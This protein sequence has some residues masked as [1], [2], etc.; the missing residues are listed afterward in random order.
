[1]SYFKKIQEAVDYIEEN[2]S[3]DLSLE[4]LAKKFSFSKYHFHRL[5]LSIVGKPLMGYVQER[6]LSQA[7]HQ[8]IFSNQTVT[9]IALEL[10]YGSP[11]VFERAFKRRYG[12]NPLEYRKKTNLKPPEMFPRKETRIMDDWNLCNKTACSDEEKHECLELLNIIIHLSKVAHRDGLLS[13]ESETNDSWPFLLQKGLQLLLYGTEPLVLRQILENYIRA[14]GYEGKELLSRILIIEGILAIQMGR[15]PWEIRELLAGFFGE[16]YA[17]EIERNFGIDRENADRTIENFITGLRNQ[18]T[19]SSATT[20]LEHIVD[21]L[22][23]HSLQ[24]ALRDIDLTELAAG[25]KGVEGKVG[26]KIV[27]SLPKKT[28]LILVE[29]Y[30]LLE[31]ITAPQ[32]VNAQNAIAGRIK[33]LRVEGEIP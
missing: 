6:R 1:M 32:I 22:D 11:D 5:F 3:G 4:I 7:A 18:K 21:R 14:G 26:M 2:L 29:I 31:D 30:D 16:G 20:I 15:Y 25:L 12:L 8:L 19:Y 28:T 13:L 17:K 23:H 33:K 9:K 10:N 24:R 27:E